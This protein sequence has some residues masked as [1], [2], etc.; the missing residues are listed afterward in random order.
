MSEYLARSRVT[1]ALTDSGLAP[2]F[3]AAEARLDAIV[4]CIAVGA[5]MMASQAGQTAALTAVVTA[6]K[7]FG[8]VVVA[9]EGLETPLHQPLLVGD[10]LGSAAQALGA[11]IEN[12]IPEKTTHLIR[13]GWYVPW[14]GWQVAGWWNRWLAGTRRDPE[15]VGGATLSLAGMF[16]GALAVRQIFAHALDGMPPREETVSLWEPGAP[17]Q[18]DQIGPAQCTLPGKLWLLG[19]GH[20]GQAFI[21]G[22]LSLPLRGE[23]YAILQDDQWVAVENEATSVLVG[24]GDLDLRKARL[25]AR[26]LDHA[27]WTTELIERRH[28]GDIR[29]MPHDPQI[30]LA[31]LDSVKARRTLVAHGF[32]YMI[33]AG[34]GRG[35]RGFET[36]QIRTIPAG[37]SI[38]GLWLAEDVETR[39]DQVMGKDAYVALE[40]D[41][42]QCGVVPLA[43]AS[44]SVPFV[45]AATAALSLAQLARLGAM[46]TTS[47]LLQIELGA[48]GMVIDGGAVGAPE[49]FLGGQ[50]FALD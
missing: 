48:P 20:L 19:L 47:A 24:P 9:G 2:S 12:A 16:A 49:S 25:A 42:G 30:L 28:R 8:R 26:W 29:R 37:T 6:K 31:G 3:A 33:D 23:R 14:E 46:Q 45:G 4:P 32:D 50:T 35:A 5:D 38:D 27:G 7:C 11:S 18:F 10:S 1:K 15:P 17:A 22:L 39:R 41:I 13:L 43:D 40:Q 36:L 44:V 21:W 34:I